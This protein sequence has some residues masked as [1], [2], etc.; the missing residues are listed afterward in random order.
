MLVPPLPVGTA[1]NEKAKSGREKNGNLVKA[2]SW[3]AADNMCNRQEESG[4][5]RQNGIREYEQLD[6]DAN[7]HWMNTTQ[8]DQIICQQGTR[9]EGGGIKA[10]QGS[11]SQR[12]GN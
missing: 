10:R 2:V 1:V 8:I 11:S 9:G 3:D 5:S 6:P 4:D 7:S 12:N